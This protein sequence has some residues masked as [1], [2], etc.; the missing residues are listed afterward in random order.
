MESVAGL[1]LVFAGCGRN[2]LGGNP[3][4]PYP[5]EPAGAVVL[6][7]YDTKF[8]NVSDPPWGSIAT[9]PGNLSTITDP[10]APVNPNTVGAVRFTTGCCAGSGPARLETYV[11]PGRGTPPSGWTR[12]YV[13]DWVKFDPTFRPDAGIQKL[14]PFY[15]NAGGEGGI[16]CS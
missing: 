9:G 3:G 16:G 1:C 13:S 12:W 15:I 10:S 2:V 6:M 4:A 5:N 11:G 14:F 7:D 8:G